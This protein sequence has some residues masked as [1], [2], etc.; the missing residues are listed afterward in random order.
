MSVIFMRRMFRYLIA[1]K[2]WFAWGLVVSVPGCFGTEAD[3]P[4]AGPVDSTPCKKMPEYAS[5]LAQQS[6]A[7]LGAQSLTSGFGSGGSGTG[8]SFAS[9]A[10][11]LTVDEQVPLAL[12]C[13]EWTYEGE[14]LHL[15]ISNFLGGCG[16]EWTGGAGLSA[17]GQV[18]VQLDKSECADAACGNCS[19]DTRA[20]VNVSAEDLVASG[21]ATTQVT[22]RL[23]NCKGEVTRSY[24]WSVPIAAEP[25]GITC[26]AIWDFFAVQSASAGDVFSEADVNLYARCED[27]EYPEFTKTCTEDRT[28]VDG[29]CVPPCAVDGD[30]PLG[31]ALSCIDGACLLPAP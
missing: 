31:G 5:Y 22:L 12:E 21:T 3:N 13:L 7:G 11:A 16:N 20:Q 9:I 2:R 18:V 17:P 26:R 4:F 28:C 27:A 1:L 29:Y 14:T 19:Y 23:T 8:A 6:S 24:E 25:S 30:C 10:Q 15:Q